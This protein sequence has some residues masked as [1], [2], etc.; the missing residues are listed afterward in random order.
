MR[1]AQGLGER[2][3]IG[4]TVEHGPTI[5]RYAELIEG[6]RLLPLLPDAVRRRLTEVDRYV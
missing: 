4:L 5:E 3:R 1:G 6:Q 2:E